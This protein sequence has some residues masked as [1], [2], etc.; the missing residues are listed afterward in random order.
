M[1]QQIHLHYIMTPKRL[2]YYPETF[3]EQATHQNT[4]TWHAGTN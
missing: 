1:H 4:L 2:D 3:K